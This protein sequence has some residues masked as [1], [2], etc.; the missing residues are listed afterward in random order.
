MANHWH[1]SSGATVTT[2]QRDLLIRKAKIR[3]LKEFTN[4]H[5][6]VFCEVCGI[7]SGIFIDMSHTI[8][9]KKCCEEGKAELSWDVNNIKFRC[10]TCHNIHDKTY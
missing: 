4:E 8:S 7:S 3:K 6:Y 1:T 9:V 5:G 10:R 2:P